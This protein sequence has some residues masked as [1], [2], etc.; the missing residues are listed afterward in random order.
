MEGSAQRVQTV[1][2]ESKEEWIG[3]AGPYHLHTN[4]QGFIEKNGAIGPKWLAGANIFNKNSIKELKKSDPLLS[5]TC[6]SGLFS[7][8][9]PFKDKCPNHGIHRSL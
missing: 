5:P 8:F 3:R 9:I 1:E 4:R 2:H 7:L 6:V